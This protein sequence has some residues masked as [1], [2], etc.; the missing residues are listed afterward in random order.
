M[1]PLRTGYAKSQKW[2]VTVSDKDDLLQNPLNWNQIKDCEGNTKQN[3]YLSG[4]NIKA[5][6]IHTY[7]DLI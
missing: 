7:L 2:N 1:Y 4:K 6:I 3:K 5:K